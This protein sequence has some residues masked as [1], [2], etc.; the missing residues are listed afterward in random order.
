MEPETPEISP[1]VEAVVAETVVAD[2][3]LSRFAIPKRAL[4]AVTAI[5]VLVLAFVAMTTFVYRHA[6]TDSSVRKI[7]GAIPYPAAVIGNH[8]IT[9]RD[10][11]GER[12]A[13]NTYFA[14]QSGQSGAP[15]DEVAVTKSVMDTM[16][17]KV[18][19]ADLAKAAGITLDDAKAAEFYAD[20]LGGADESTFAE[21]LNAVFGWTPDEF[22]E[23]VVKP[24]V[25]SVQ[26]SESI[27]AD[28]SRQADRLAKAQAAYDRV[29]SGEDF[30]AVA[31]DVSADPSAAAGGDVGD[32]KVSDIP[33][34]W[35]DAVAA[36]A[37]GDYSKVVEG[38]AMYL[39]FKVVARTGK[40]ADESVRL[41]LIAV[42]KETLEEATEEYLASV[43]VW[44]YIGN[45]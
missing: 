3:K 25:L 20:A 43:R 40:D 12:D 4:R 32:V 31:T 8:V 5:A 22:K 16:V 19:V 28:A 9:M 15:T 1:P 14:S 2:P 23:R 21:Q 26:V 27:Q 38:K 36:V 17:N 33:A 18:V 13:L 24:V 41:S 35:K 34:E 37:V 30:A 10:Y 44:R 45:T 42:H 7:V 11:L 29:A 6:P 39:V